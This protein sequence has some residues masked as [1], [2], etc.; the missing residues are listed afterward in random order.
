MAAGS[1]PLDRRT[2]V[3]MHLALSGGYT[4]VGVVLGVMVL[5]HHAPLIPDQLHS[6]LPWALAAVALPSLALAMLWARPRVPIRAREMPVEA[7]WAGTEAGPRALVC[8]VLWEGSGMI[9][10]VGTLLTGAVPTAAVAMIALALLVLH[11]PVY[12][13]SREY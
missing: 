6:V 13:E 11:T 4:L 9:G 2:V 3:L 12:F 5:T 1:R 8:W 10:L 7:Y